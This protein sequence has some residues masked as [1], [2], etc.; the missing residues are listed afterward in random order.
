MSKIKTL[1]VNGDELPVGVPADLSCDTVT[2]GTLNDDGSVVVNGTDATLRVGTVQDVGSVR[3]NANGSLPNVQVGKMGTSADASAALSCNNTG[4]GLL[5]LDGQAFRASDIG[6]SVPS[7]LSCTSL[8]V[9]AYDSQSDYQRHANLEITQDNSVEGG[10]RLNLTNGETVLST[11]T[12]ALGKVDSDGQ[13]ARIGRI[14]SYYPELELYDSEAYT[15]LKGGTSKIGIQ[16]RSSGNDWA[17]LT[18]GDMNE[19]CLKLYDYGNSQLVTLT[20][21][22]LAALLAFIHNT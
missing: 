8:S 11:Y 6:G 10:V 3:I 5:V 19:G 2:V 7:N 14:N 13:Y 17:V 16:E 15:K 1:F 20:A 18:I 22:D 21:S 12:L 9:G 4:N